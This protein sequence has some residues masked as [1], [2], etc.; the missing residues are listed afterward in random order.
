MYEFA[1]FEYQELIDDQKVEDNANT[2]V[3]EK[4]KGNYPMPNVYEEAIQVNVLDEISQSYSH[5]KNPKLNVS[6]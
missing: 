6:R 3:L 4:I 1:S 5:H 2:N